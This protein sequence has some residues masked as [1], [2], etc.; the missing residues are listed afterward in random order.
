MPT[1]IVLPRRD[2][3][4]SMPRRSKLAALKEP[5]FIAT[6]AFALTGLVLTIGAAMMFDLPDGLVA[7]LAA[8][9]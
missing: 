6:A 3:G 2:A 5:D 7:L 1:T 4:R 8:S 9:F